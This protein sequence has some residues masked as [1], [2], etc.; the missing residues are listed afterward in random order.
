VRNTYA[1]YPEQEYSSGKLEL[2]LHKIVEE[3][4]SA[5]KTTVVLDGHAFD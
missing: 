5:I 4:F 1:T 2:T 3:H